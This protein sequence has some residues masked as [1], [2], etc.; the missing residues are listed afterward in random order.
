MVIAQLPGGPLPP[1]GGEEV[2]VGRLVKVPPP[3]DFDAEPAPGAALPGPRVLSEAAR[4]TC[5]RLAANS[6]VLYKRDSAAGLGE[7]LQNQHRRLVLVVA[8]HVC[9]AGVW[10]ML[11]LDSDGELTTEAQAKVAMHEVAY[12]D[13]VTYDPDIDQMTSP[14]TEQ[15]DYPDTCCGLLAD[16]HSGISGPGA[17][18][19][20]QDADVVVACMHATGMRAG[21]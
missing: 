2:S 18:I 17:R 16:Q 20:G 13:E 6:L 15:S 9:Q 12:V 4:R 10:K 21:R 19:C 7:V 11:F 5:V 14:S 3:C 8:E 1:R